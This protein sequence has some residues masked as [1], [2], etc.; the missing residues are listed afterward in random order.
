MNQFIALALIVWI[1][2]MLLTAY[3]AYERIKAKRKRERFER[4]LYRWRIN[5]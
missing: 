3:L 4:S 2:A 1:F 5:G